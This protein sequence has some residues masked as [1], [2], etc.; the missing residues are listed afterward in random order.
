MSALRAWREKCGRATGVVFPS[1]T[2]GV[3]ARWDDLG[4]AKVWREQLGVRT[5]VRWHDLRHTAASALVMGYWDAPWTLE[6]IRAF[7]GHKTI[8]S[9]QRYAHLDPD[10]LPVPDSPLALDSV[11]EDWSQATDLTDSQAGAAAPELPLSTE[12]HGGP[13]ESRTRNRRVKSPLLYH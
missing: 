2:G 7:L 11:T 10:A 4:W 3:R 5:G 8:L 6:Q 1:E 9:T 12:N 13:R